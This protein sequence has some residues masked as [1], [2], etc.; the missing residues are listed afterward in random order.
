MFIGHERTA[1]KFDFFKGD[2]LSP[3]RWGLASRPRRESSVPK[4]KLS[5]SFQVPFETPKKKRKLREYES[6]LE[7]EDDKE[8]EE[9]E[10]VEQEFPQRTGLEMGYSVW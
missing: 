8:S 9:Q 6:D 7:E 1:P 3:P 2:G 5:V 10:M 4:K